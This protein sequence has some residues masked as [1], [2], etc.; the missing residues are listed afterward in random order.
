MGNERALDTAERD[1]AEDKRNQKLLLRGQLLSW[2]GDAMQPVAVA[3]AILLNDGSATEVGLA[4]S[5][6][7]AGRL[8]ATL[9]GGVL[10]DRMRPQSLMIGSDIA[11][12]LLTLG[13]LWCF[14]S[15]GRID[16]ALVLLFLHGGVGGVFL[17][18]LSVLKVRVTTADTRLSFNSSVASV[19]TAA[20][21]VGPV[22]GGGLAAVSEP[23]V[24]FGI[25]AATF[26]ISA[27]SIRL[28]RAETSPSGKSG[29][30]LR[31]FADGAKLVARRRWLL[32]CMIC[33]MIHSLAFGVAITLM[34]VGGLEEHGSFGLGWIVGAQGV[35]TFLGVQIS[36]KLTA[37]RPMIIAWFGSLTIPLCVLAFLGD[38]PFPVVLVLVAAGLLGAGIHSVLYES[39]LQ[40]NIPGEEIGR[41]ASWDYVVSL[42]TLP[43][44]TAIAG[45][46]IDGIGFRRLVIACT[47]TFVV[48]SLLPL[49]FRRV[50]E[51]SAHGSE[52]D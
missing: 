25:N 22:L 34:Q 29:A 37:E 3:A 39:T 45:I 51:V 14:L 5:A 31:D 20:T 50:R 4:T 26:V 23:A 33:T 6:F 36:K 10:A 47:V 13:V 8:I 7:G 41:V 18:A 2:L 32:I 9:F 17:P 21:F 19:K 38:T 48:A 28:M 49:A 16:I 15:P 42:A 30:F 12:T 43:I 40:N 11:R 27:V 35:G 24:V 52:S 1:Q 44:G 46:L